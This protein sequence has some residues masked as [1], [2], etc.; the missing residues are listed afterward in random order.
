[1]SSSDAQAE[2]EALKARVQA[3]K[4]TINELKGLNESLQERLQ[5]RESSSPTSTPRESSRPAS[6]ASGVSATSTIQRECV[7]YLSREKKGK[8]FSGGSPTVFYE[9][10]DELNAILSYRPYSGADKAAYIYEQLSGEAKQEIRYRSLAERKDPDRIL[11]ILKDIY[12]RPQSLTKLQRQFFDRRQK[13]GESVREFSHALMAIMEEIKQCPVNAAWS[14]DSALRDQFA[15]N[16]F[17]PSLRRELKRLIRQDSTISFFAL[18]KEAL[19]WAE[20]GDTSGKRVVNS[21]GVEADSVTETNAVAAV[22]TPSPD[23]S[24]SEILD[25]LR[26]QQAQLDDVTQKLAQVQ[27]SN[28]LGVS[29]RQQQPRFDS[30]GRPICFKCQGVG[31]IARNCQPRG[32]QAI[33]PRQIRSEPMQGVVHVTEQQGNFTPLWRGAE[34]QEGHE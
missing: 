23:P 20:D 28:R 30:S 9:W 33:G 29:R 19:L 5:T 2:L 10:L 16:V 32:S 3:D 27:T 14:S 17:D 11:E 22:R 6:R 34:P 4:E 7:M 25:I 24:L 21:C 15:E 13:E 8:P 12:G 26:K 1:M 31:H 18:R